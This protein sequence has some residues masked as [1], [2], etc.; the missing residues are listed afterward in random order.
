M[1]RECSSGKESPM[2]APTRAALRRARVWLSVFRDRHRRAFLPVDAA[3]QALG[4]LLGCIAF[5]L[6]L[7]PM[8]LSAGCLA[9]GVVTTMFRW[10][11]NDTGRR[12]PRELCLREHLTVHGIVFD[13]DPLT[14]PALAAAVRNRASVLLG[15]P[16]RPLERCLL[17]AIFCILG[18]LG[19]ARALRT[20]SFSIVPVAV[21][22]IVSAPLMWCSIPFLITRRHRAEAAYREADRILRNDAR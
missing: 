10:L 19:L 3:V 4:F 12:F 11:T 5:D 18:T 8:A 21:A 1:R 20:D 22:L 9:G 17:A 13:G 16:Y 6:Q 7:D 2:F 14:D 15:R